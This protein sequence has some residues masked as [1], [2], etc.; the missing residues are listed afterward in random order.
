LKTTN[1]PQSRQS[2]PS[3]Y[4]AVYN[5]CR[6]AVGD[7]HLSEQ[8]IEKL[9]SS[10]ALAA[11]YSVVWRTPLQPGDIATIAIRAWADAATRSAGTIEGGENSARRAPPESRRGR[12]FTADPAAARLRRRLTGQHQHHHH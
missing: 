6:D 5:A 2:R 11:F 10:A 3:I 1:K 7:R 12:S 8:E 4:H 9:I